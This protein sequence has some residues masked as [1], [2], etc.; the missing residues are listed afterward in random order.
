MLANDREKAVAQNGPG[1]VTGSNT[2]LAFPTTLENLLDA[3]PAFLTRA[4]QA[5]G[6]LAAD[7]AVTAVT[8]HRE[9]HGG[10]MGRKLWLEVAYA[11]PDPGLHNR[12]FAKFTREFGDPLLDLFGPLMEP[13]VRLALLSLRPD[14]PVRVPRCYFADFS[15]D[16]LC[17]LLITERVPYGEGAVLPCPDKG[18]DWQLDDP[19]PY[20]R[21]VI[22]AAAQL[23][24][25]HRAGLLGSAIDTSFP[26]D[27]QVI[28]PGSRIPYDAPQLARQLEAVRG[29]VAAAPQLFSGPCNVERFIAEVPMVLDLE[30]AIRRELNQDAAM[31]ALCHWNLNLD[32]AWFERQADGTLAAGLLDWGSVAQMN[33]A[34][35]FFGIT[36]AA[37]PDFLARHEADLARLFVNRY[38]EAGGPKVSPER[39]HFLVKL[40]MAVLGTAWML[41]APAIVARELPGFA[42][43]ENRFDPRLTGHFLARAQTHL[44]WVF[45]SEWTNQDIGGALRQ[46]ADGQHP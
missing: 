28:D 25:S 37:E 8:T 45:I 24:G 34:Q 6:V 21:A 32:N 3:G 12:L 33:I 9:F 43:L 20:Y 18:M 44:L 26:F 5:T 38:A 40:S 31:V 15:A 13:E 30:E 41:D 7:N 10:G 39:M 35:S 16:P 23:A 17:G 29:F 22:E 27:P 36:C 46:F 11:R 1:S 14:F 4:F 19:L 42:E 2:G